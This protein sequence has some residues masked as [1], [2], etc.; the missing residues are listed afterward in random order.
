MEDVSVESNSKFFK[1]DET[2]AIRVLPDFRAVLSDRYL[3][4][5]SIVIT[6]YNYASY[7]DGCI[8]SIA[9]Q[10]YTKFECVVVNDCSTDDTESV[11]QKNFALRRDERFLYVRTKDNLGQ[12]GAQ[13]FG[14][15]DCSGSFVVFVDADDL[16]LPHFVE[17]QVFFHLNTPFPV[18]FSSA[19]QLVCEEQGALVAATCRDFVKLGKFGKARFLRVG[20]RPS[21]EP[22]EALILPAWDTQIAGDWLWGQQSAMMFRRSV[23]DL[24][25]PPP[26]DC[27]FFRICADT[28]LAKL[29]HLIGNSAL[30]FERLGV[31]RRHG[32]NNFACPGT[33]SYDCA[34]GDMSRHPS[35]KDLASFALAL[36]KAR[37]RSFI[38]N[39][40]RWRYET[41]QVI[42][43]SWMS[44]PG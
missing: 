15:S 41:A 42:L 7:I 38:F 32:N 23:L 4:L 12:L 29:S 30:L 39:L 35:A 3:P 8:A 17:R 2:L 34:G 18:A 11:V 1:D 26:Q 24:I 37:E 27:G 10:T 14:L 20:S 28:Y 33:I 5:V 36:M 19:D 31:Y 43:K 22:V 21:S 44:E 25:V 6:A 40:G 9:E 16:L 13:A